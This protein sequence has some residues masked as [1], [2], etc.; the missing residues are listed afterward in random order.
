MWRTPN[1]GVR[2]LWNI[3]K[4]ALIGFAVLLIIVFAAGVK[5]SELRSARQADEEI[6]LY[7]D[8][9]VP[10]EEDQADAIDN[11]GEDA[12]IKVYV[13]GQI[14]NPGVYELKEGSRIYEAIALAGGALE[15]SELRYLDMARVL[16]DE[17]TVL[18]PGEGEFSIENNS[19]AS[20]G[21]A[22]SSKT[23][24]VNI[25]TASANELAEK[26]TGIGPVLAER[27]VDYRK[28]NGGF[29]Q[30]EDLKNVNGIGDKRFE[31]LKNSICVR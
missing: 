29:K 3:D 24:K 14:K 15:D 20:S 1:Y 19:S 18:V 2:T 26:L 31:D 17:D 5:Y 12:I 30:I 6:V 28:T 10:E 23:A 22:S 9:Q 7:M 21:S 16:Q 4:K 25:N 11:D 13:C 8:A 27:I